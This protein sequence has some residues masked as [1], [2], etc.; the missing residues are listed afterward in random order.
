MK[1]TICKKCRFLQC[2]RV[3]LDPNKILMNSGQ[4]IKF[5]H[6]KGHS[7]KRKLKDPLSYKTVFQEYQDHHGEKENHGPK[8]VGS[9]P[10][11][12]YEKAVVPINEIFSN[13]QE[14]LSAQ[15]PKN[16]MVVEMNYDYEQILSEYQVLYWYRVHEFR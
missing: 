16:S 12:H 3:G 14:V 15:K 6:P 1:R 2:H 11:N 13:C 7:R 9:N 10:D 4:R 8:D 5:S